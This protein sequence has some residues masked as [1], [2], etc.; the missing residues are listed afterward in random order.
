MKS[1][2][3]ALSS[4]FS[5]K[6]LGLIHYFLAVE[7]THASDGLLL[8]QHKYVKDL[9]QD[10]NMAECKGAPTPMTSTCTFETSRE[11]SKVDGTLYR[12]V[13]GKLHYLSFTRPDIAFAV[14]KLSQF[15]HQPGVSHW[16]TVK[17]LLRYLCHTAHLGIKLA[18]KSATQLVAYSDS[19][20]AGD[21]FDRTS[22]TGYVV[23]LGDSPISWSSKKQRSVSRS[24]TE[25]E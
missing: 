22:I 12:R 25:A 4:R 17:R 3:N 15:M 19:D 1:I 24:S 23:Y 16:K 21:P 11:D 8:S 13:I 2:I 18:K 5:I 6:D 20:W 7:V 10:V 9:L 14:S